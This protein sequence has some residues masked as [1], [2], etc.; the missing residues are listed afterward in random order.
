MTVNIS[1]TR[2]SLVSTIIS[3]EFYTSNNITMGSFN[4]S[5]FSVA[6]ANV[7]YSFV[8]S[9]GPYIPQD[10]SLQLIIPTEVGISLTGYVCTFAGSSQTGN[11]SFISSNNQSILTFNFKNS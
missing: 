7:L 2:Y 5:D 8:F 6:S 9:I 4:Q 11:P 1:S 10:A 3:R